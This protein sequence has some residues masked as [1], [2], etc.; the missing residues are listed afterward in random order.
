MTVVSVVLYRLYCGYAGRVLEARESRSLCAVLT[1]FLYSV[2]R[3]YGRAELRSAENSF[4]RVVDEGF[5]WEKLEVGQ[6][7]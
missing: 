1:A 2:S 3:V 5:A 4:R 7:A 6:C